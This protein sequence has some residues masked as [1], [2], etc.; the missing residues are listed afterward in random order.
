VI[1]GY[2][3]RADGLTTEAFRATLGSLPCDEP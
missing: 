1:A 3:M 2:G